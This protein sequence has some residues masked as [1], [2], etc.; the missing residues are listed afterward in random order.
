VD[1][2]EDWRDDGTLA[3]RHKRYF[4]DG[5]QVLQV[6]FDKLELVQ[7]VWLARSVR[8]SD[9]RGFSLELRVTGYEPGFPVPDDVLTLQTP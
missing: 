2:V 9:S 5:K 8:L 7:G 1:A 3:L 6:D 4:K